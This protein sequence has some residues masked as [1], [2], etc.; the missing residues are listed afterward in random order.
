MNGDKMK[1]YEVQPALEEGSRIR[2]Q[3]WGNLHICISLFI[4]HQ[5]R[6]I[7]SNQGA[8]VICDGKM[9]LDFYV[10]EIKMHEFSQDDILADDWEILED[11]S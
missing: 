6:V 5:G 7:P 8:R 3:S 1:F 11:I 10:T 4:L 2:R 9:L